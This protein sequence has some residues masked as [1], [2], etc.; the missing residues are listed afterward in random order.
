MKIYRRWLLKHQVWELTFKIVTLNQK[1][2]RQSW[3]TAKRSQEV[4]LQQSLYQK[5]PVQLCQDGA[6]IQL[7]H[8]QCLWEAENT[9]IRMIRTNG[10]ARNTFIFRS[11]PVRDMRPPKELCPCPACTRPQEDTCQDRPRPSPCD[12][13]VTLP[14]W[15]RTTT[16]GD[17]WSPTTRSRMLATFSTSTFLLDT[18]VTPGS[19]TTERDRRVEW[20]N[21]WTTLE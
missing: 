1:Y 14:S 19:S 15:S 10:P 21:W 17:R 5:S 13:H 8:P 20:I 9:R 6:L 12:L 2:L 7:Q 16:W 11:E 3:E 4:N 18:S